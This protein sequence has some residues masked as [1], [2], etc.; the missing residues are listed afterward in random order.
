[1]LESQSH[2][3][4]L[5][6]YEN[7]HKNYSWSWHICNYVILLSCAVYQHQFIAATYSEV[8]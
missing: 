7:N 4:Y 3:S 1:M 8:S 6:L 2:G 5:S